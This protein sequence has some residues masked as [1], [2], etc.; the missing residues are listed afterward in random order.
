MLRGGAGARAE[1]CCA[2]NI[3][4]YLSK[5]GQASLW[6]GLPATVSHTVDE[7]SPLANISLEQMAERGMQILVMVDGTD[8]MT[9]NCVQARASLA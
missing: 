7:S 9:S 8:K 1:A 4:V 6:L 3:D 2:Q 5:E